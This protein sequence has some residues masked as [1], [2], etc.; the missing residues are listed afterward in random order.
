MKELT[1]RKQEDG[2]V[3]DEYL[4]HGTA[5]DRIGI[6]VIKHWDIERAGRGPHP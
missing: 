4:S 6:I 2:N 5:A 1:K 3:E